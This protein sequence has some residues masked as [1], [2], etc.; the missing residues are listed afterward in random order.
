MLC[1]RASIAPA[2]RPAAA[3]DT[4]AA[5][6]RSSGNVRICA[7][8]DLTLGTNLD[9]A[10]MARAA[11][12]RDSIDPALPGPD[13][14][15]APLRPLVD[16]ADIVLLNIEGALGDDPAPEKCSTGSSF[17][18]AMRSP[19]AAAAAIRRVSERAELV[20]NLANNHA[21]DAGADGLE[22]TIDHL[23]LAGVN[24]TGADTLATEVVTARGD[25]V[26]ILGF[27]ISGVPDVRDLAGVR[28]HVGRA[29]AR[30]RRVIVTMHLGAEGPTSQRTR[31]R[32]ERYA[33]SP[34][35]NPVAFAEA[36][37]G[38]GADLVVGHGPH[39]VRALQW[40]RGGHALVAYSLGNLL[41]YGPFSLREPLDRG[42]VLCVT[43]NRAGSVTRA[44]LRATR[45]DAFGRLEVD[46][47][48][49]ALLLADSLSRLDFPGTGARIAIDGV[50]RRRASRKPASRP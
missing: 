40:R 16:S 27:S 3:A 1:A 50:I 33:G 25:T 4:I 37:I 17:C 42:A 47:T 32:M 41:T 38:A 20:G 24:V 28:R 49:R 19:S 23:A 22:I 30:Y 48:H 5:V 35:G 43:M 14:L 9:T 29:A 26:A 10:W 46:E 11:R 44:R 36:A 6:R 31:N 15:L 7:G 18:Y 13:S 2:Q 12:A 39:V 21:R 8:G 34:R 45:Q